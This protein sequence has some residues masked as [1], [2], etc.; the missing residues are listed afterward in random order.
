[1]QYL[2]SDIVIGDKI[3]QQSARIS[4]TSNCADKADLFLYYENPFQKEDIL[5]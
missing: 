4:M 2:N 3:F 1:M 5:F